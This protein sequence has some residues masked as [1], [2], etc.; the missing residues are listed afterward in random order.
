MTS[1]TSWINFDFHG[2]ATMRVDESAPTS[3]LLRDMFFPFIT[4]AHIDQADL[5]V[6]GQM[7]Q[8]GDVSYGET[9]YEY[10]QK[11]LYI[12]DT[13]VQILKD[14]D[15]F[16]VNGSREL[17][18]SVLPILDRI[19]VARGAA[20]V[21]AATIEYKGHAINLPAWGGTG[22]T[23]TIAKLL[24]RDGYAF[25]GD[26]WAFLTRDGRLLAYAKPMFIK[27]HHRPIYPH[28]FSSV[29]KPLVPVRFSRPLGK[30]TTRVHPIITQYPR[31]ARATRKFSPEHMMVRPEAAFPHARFSSGGP[32]A[33]NIFVERHS[34]DT[35]LVD[36]TSKE[37]MVSRIIGNFHA[38]VTQHS[39][40]VVTAL[41]ASGLVPI[42][43]YFADKADVVR[44]GINGT[45][46]YLMR[47]P[48]AFSPDQA[49]DAIVIELERIM[50][51]HGLLH[52]T[53]SH[54]AAEERPLERVPAGAIN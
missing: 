21:H 20:M 6:T 4:Q 5:T 47:V 13:G 10:S 17:L 41:A 27:P 33:L 49:S 46:T 36:E 29:R 31:L 23:S 28:L 26:D 45:P 38:E 53:N 19:L 50:S 3:P 18:V 34:G 7:A 9:E 25:M 32:L 1:G 15:R 44:E 14:G 37:W 43:Q 30:L 8:V 42:E 12:A 40:Q 35:V 39:Q 51:T 2:L 52:S 16:T 22:K 24:R 11:S 48:Q 54:G